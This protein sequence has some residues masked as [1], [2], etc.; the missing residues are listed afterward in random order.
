MQTISPGLNFRAAASYLRPYST[1]TSHAGS[2]SSRLIANN[3]TLTLELRKE[4]DEAFRKRKTEWKRRQGVRHNLAS[5]NTTF[6]PD[7]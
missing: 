7:S 4:Q 6:T 3:K 1:F 2:K 5:T